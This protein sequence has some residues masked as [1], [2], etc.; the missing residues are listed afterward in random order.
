[1]TDCSVNKTVAVAVF[2]VTRLQIYI[3]CNN[4]SEYQISFTCNYANKIIKK[5]QA[6]DEE[7]SLKRMAQ[8][9]DVP[10]PLNLRR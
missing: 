2:G 10:L 8:G 3:L 5:Q 9:V 7:I 6:I 1:M 4:F